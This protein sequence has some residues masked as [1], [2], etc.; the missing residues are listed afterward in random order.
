MQLYHSNQQ[1]LDQM[2]ALFREMDALQRGPFRR[3]RR[4]TAR[5]A[6]STVSAWLDQF[7]NLLVIR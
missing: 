4:A 1:Y 7:V 6:R 3:Y 2:D 5:P